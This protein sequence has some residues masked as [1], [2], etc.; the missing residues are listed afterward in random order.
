[1]PK[2]TV[3]LTVPETVALA[4]LAEQELRDPREQIR[5][6]VRRELLRRGLLEPEPRCA[7]A[8]CESVAEVAQ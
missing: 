1:M 7:P 2:L 3:T 4:R 6:L 8:P 5:A